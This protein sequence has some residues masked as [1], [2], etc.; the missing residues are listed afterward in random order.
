MKKFLTAL[1]VGLLFVAGAHAAQVPTYTGP[2]GTNP[3]DPSNI[4]GVINQIIQSYDLAIGNGAA[5]GTHVGLFSEGG[6]QFSGG[7]SV[8]SLTLGLVQP[9]SPNGLVSNTAKFF[10]T[11]FDSKGVQSYIPVWQ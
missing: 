5:L 1:V 8:G 9:T 6:F 11:F 10:I 7:N 3:Y 2:A 4:A